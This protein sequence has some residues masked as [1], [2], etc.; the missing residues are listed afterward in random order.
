MRSHLGFNKLHCMM[1][2]TMNMPDDTLV[3]SL[4]GC[5]LDVN[6]HPIAQLVIVNMIVVLSSL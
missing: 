6:M 4:R 2:S 3:T 1:K 5:K